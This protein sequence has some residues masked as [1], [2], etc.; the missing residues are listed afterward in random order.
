MNKRLL[1]TL[2]CPIAKCLL[3]YD[4]TRQELV[5]RPMRLAYPIRSGI[6]ILLASEAR[7]I[8]EP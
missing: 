2:V 1:A 5:S 7:I 3:D 4:E 8:K 6:P